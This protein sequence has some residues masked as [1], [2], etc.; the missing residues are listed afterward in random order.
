MFRPEKTELIVKVV[1]RYVLR[2]FMKNIYISLFLLTYVQF[3]SIF[4]LHYYKNWELQIV[5]LNKICDG[6]VKQT[7]KHRD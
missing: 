4:H 7:Y 5:Q 6:Y 2:V 3:V 1:H